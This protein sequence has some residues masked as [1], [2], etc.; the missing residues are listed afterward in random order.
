MPEIKF[1]IREKPQPYKNLTRDER[2]I[3]SL[4]KS[5]I[6]HAML[7]TWKKVQDWKRYR[8]TVEKISLQYDFPRSP[9]NKVHMHVQFYFSDK[10]HGNP[11]NYWQAIAVSVFKT[12]KQLSGSFDFD[13]DSSPRVEVQIICGEKQE[14]KA[15]PEKKNDM[16]SLLDRAMC[17]INPYKILSKC[18]DKSY[19]KD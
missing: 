4:P 17:V 7:P 2:Y 15:A 11:V 18:I 8:N 6:G 9:S 1:V 13:Y 16:Q 10:K 12:T 14:K 3:M 5:Q 19:G